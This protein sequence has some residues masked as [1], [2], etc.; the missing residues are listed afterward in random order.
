[1]PHCWNSWPTTSK[2]VGVF[3]TIL[4]GHEAAPARQAVPLRLLSGLHRLTLDSWATELRNWYHSVG[5]C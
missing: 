3:A 5:S 2:T 1:M 4:A